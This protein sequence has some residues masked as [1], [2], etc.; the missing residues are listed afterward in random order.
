MTFPL[1]KGDLGLVMFAEAGIG[2][3]L[4]GTGTETE[5]DSPARFQLTDA[6]FIPGV[7][8]FR[9]VPNSDNIITVDSNNV[10]TIKVKEGS[11]V[12]LDGTG[13]IKDKAGSEIELDGAGVISIGGASGGSLEKIVLGETLQSAID[14][15]VNHLIIA[16]TATAVGPASFDPTTV[17]NLTADLAS[18]ASAL[19]LSNGVKAN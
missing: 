10:M 1:S 13:I 12:K 3:Y 5:A 7:S 9:A 15:L 2:G 19:I 14:S 16:V 18:F 4:S 6:V 11:E 17:A 8:P